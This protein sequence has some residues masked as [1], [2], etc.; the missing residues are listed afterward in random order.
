MTRRRISFGVEC[1]KKVTIVG[2]DTRLKKV[3]Q[4]LMT[5]GFAVDTV[6]LYEGD[7][8]NIATSKI[9]ILPVP[10][11]RDGVNV[12]APL[13]G[14]IIPLSHIED[15]VSSDTQVLCCN[16]T[17]KKGR[18]TDYNCLDSYALLNAVPTAEGAI[19]IA[20][21][22]TPFTLWG[23]R[24]LVIGYGRVGKILADRLKG[25]GCIV[26]V[27]ARKKT[28]FALN[29]ALN[30]AKTDTRGLNDTPLDYDIIFNT[31]DFTVL[32]NRSLE[33]TKCK[34]IIDL[35]SK[36]GFDLDFAVSKGI[37]AIIAPGLPVKVAPETA[38][39]ILA[40]T[41]TQLII[42]EG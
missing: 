25:L 38:G 6:G 29:N 5:E 37:T 21:E 24:V 16:Y 27:S 30:M 28:D 36:G 41:I 1:V 18:C 8:G 17:F 40:E 42:Q 13:T 12:Y 3:E 9:V 20:I 11:T 31:V 34:C 22:S 19:K 7:N 15:S 2:G 35:S 14:R 32:N 39:E 33:N 10:T 26:T 23:A 4:R